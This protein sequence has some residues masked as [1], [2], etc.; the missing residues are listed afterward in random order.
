MGVL[1]DTPFIPWYLGGSGSWEA[2][3]SQNPFQPVPE[4][5]I[6]YYMFE[7]GYLLG[8]AVEHLLFDERTNDF[9]MYMLHHIC[10]IMLVVSSFLTNFT[11]LGALALYPI[12]MGDIF[13]NAA[14]GFGQTKSDKCAAFNFFTLMVVWIYTRLIVCTYTWYKMMTDFKMQEPFASMGL[15]SVCYYNNFMFFLLV[16]MNFVWFYMF[17]QIAKRYVVAGET[18]DTVG[19]LK[20]A[21]KTKSA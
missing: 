20:K 4:G 7:L 10:A 2:S 11:F 8:G 9:V 17:T 16:V 18:E 5:V 15:N 14:S 19:N 13:T 3:T 6:D 21:K 12:D 1:I